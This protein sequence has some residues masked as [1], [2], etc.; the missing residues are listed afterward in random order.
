LSGQ[1][2]HRSVKTEILEAFRRGELMLMRL[3]HV[4]IL[5]TIEKTPLAEETIVDE[6]PPPAEPVR[7][8]K[9]WVGIE[10]VDQKGSPVPGARYILET[11]DGKRRT[12]TLDN[13]GRLQVRDIDPG[14]CKVW[15]PDFDAR[16]WEG[17]SPVTD[18]IAPEPPPPTEEAATG[19]EPQGQS[20]VD[21]SP[22]PIEEKNW[23]ELE[24]VDEDGNPVPNARY[25]LCL[26]DG[27]ERVGTVGDDG[28]RREDGIP[29]G[30]CKVTFPDFDAA[31]W[32]A[33]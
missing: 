10:L 6:P 14:T 21:G 25:K 9:T 29:A 26:P 17:G 23:V 31:E 22:P 24:L 27:T 32:E 30:I 11:A 3:P 19:G 16:E 20:L 4:T 5:P 13:N 33:A 18:A 2:V 15:F 1:E 28:R 7:K 12:G 8:E